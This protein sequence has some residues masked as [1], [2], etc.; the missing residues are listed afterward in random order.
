MSHHITMV[1]DT[2]ADFSRSVTW[3]FE[4]ASSSNADEWVPLFTAASISYGVQLHPTN[5][6]LLTCAYCSNKFAARCRLAL[7]LVNT[8]PS[9]FPVMTPSGPVNSLL[10]RRWSSSN[11]VSDL[12]FRQCRRTLSHFWCW[13]YNFRQRAQLALFTTVGAGLI[14]HVQLV[15]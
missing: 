1:E 12:S 3:I 15:S 2:C 6:G 4:I 14:V 9:D 8:I 10:N 5:T 11:A 13:M 7:H